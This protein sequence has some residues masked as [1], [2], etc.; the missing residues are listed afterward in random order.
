M[1]VEEG[2]AIIGIMAACALVSFAVLVRLVRRGRSG[3]ALSIVSVAG[4]CFVILIYASGRPFGIDPVLAMSWALLY[5]LPVLLGGIAGGV[6]GWLLR[7]R[8]DRR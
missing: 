4:G 5:L 3:F 2:F 1:I 6:L 8:D 7:K